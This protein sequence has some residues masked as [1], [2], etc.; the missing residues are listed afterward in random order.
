LYAWPADGVHWR[1]LSANKRDIGHSGSGFP[2]VAAGLADLETM[3]AHLADLKPVY[4]FKGQRWSWA[5]GLEEQVLAKSS[6]SFDRR[7]R[8]VAACERFIRTA[9]LAMVSPVLGRRRPAG[10]D[11]WDLASGVGGNVTL[12]PP[13]AGTATVKG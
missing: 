2:D 13:P 3:L 1:L 8:C 4:S 5:L 7:V 9:P 10:L 11:L 6:R 12:T